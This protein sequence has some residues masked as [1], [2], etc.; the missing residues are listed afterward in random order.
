MDTTDPNITFDKNGIC[1]HC[2]NAVER[3]SQ[4]PNNIDEKSKFLKNCVKKIKLSRK[5]SSYDCIIGLSGGL[6]SSYLAFKIKKMGLKPLAIH[7]DN[8][9]NSELSVHNIN[10]IVKKLD[11]DLKTVVLNWRSFKDLQLSF[12]TASL[13]NCEAPTDHAITASLFN[14]AKKN[15]IKYILSGGNLSTESIMPKSWGHYNQDL[16]LLLNVHKRF[17]KVKLKDFPTIS[18][19]QYLYYVFILGI[20][21]IPILNYIEYNKEKSLKILIEELDL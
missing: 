13:A 6:D 11:I 12:L 5:H 4:I 3:L 15:K 17:G 19:K 20:R 2:S 8:G 21:Q 16:K 10:N 14:E 18:L 7:V 9:W 1:N